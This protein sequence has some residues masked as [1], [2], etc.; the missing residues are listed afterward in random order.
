MGKATLSDYLSS[1]SP[2]GTVYFYSHDSTYRSS[3]FSLRD[4]EAIAILETM[5]KPPERAESVYAKR[6]EYSSLLGRLTSSDFFSGIV[7]FY[8]EAGRCYAHYCSPL[9]TLVIYPNQA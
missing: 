3:L 4:D 1:T 9:G 6:W 8:N 2:D 5:G 7:N